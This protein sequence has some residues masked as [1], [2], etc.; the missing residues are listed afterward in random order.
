MNCFTHGERELEQLH[1]YCASK[2]DS[3]STA[4]VEQHVRECEACAVML[5]EQMAALA[6]KV[7]VHGYVLRQ[8]KVVRKGPSQELVDSGLVAALS[9]AYL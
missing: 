5:A 8:G 3:Q 2:L 1:S 6:L 9:S 7:S 4:E